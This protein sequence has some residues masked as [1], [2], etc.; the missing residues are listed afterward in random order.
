[1]DRR[2]IATK[3][4]NIAMCCPTNC[5]E[6]WHHPCSHVIPVPKVGAEDGDGGAARAAT[7]TRAAG[8]TRAAFR[9]SDLLLAYRAATGEIPEQLAA[10][11]DVSAKAIKTWERPS[12]HL[13]A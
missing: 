4:H 9:F 6:R 7:A 8:E 5:Q 1:M 11:L 10:I 12:D 2:L 3:S 13:G